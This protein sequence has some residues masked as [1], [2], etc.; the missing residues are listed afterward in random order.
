MLLK[1]LLIV[2]LLISGCATTS[3]KPKPEI[4]IYNSKKARFNCYDPKTEAYRDLTYT[5]ATRYI[6]MSPDDFLISLNF[7]RGAY[8]P[9][10]VG[11]P[12]KGAK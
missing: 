12:S 1:I 11:R 9:R 10:R 2:S 3:V 5:Q 6:C 4:C 8:K 7:L